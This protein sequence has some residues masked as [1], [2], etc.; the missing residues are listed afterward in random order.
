MNRAFRSF[1][2]QNRIKPRLIAILE[3][4]DITEELIFR[5][6]RDEDLRLLF[7]RAGEISVGQYA[8]LCRLWEREVHSAQGLR[9]GNNFAL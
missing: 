7:D 3:A 2:E 9:G 5:S 6:L 1:L 8:L 4:E